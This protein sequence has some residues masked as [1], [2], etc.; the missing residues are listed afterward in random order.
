MKKILAILLCVMLICITPVVAFAEDGSVD[1]GEISGAETENSTPGEG[2]TT[3]G[4]NSGL[5][6]DVNT[7]DA[8][9]DGE[10]EKTITEQIKEWIVARLDDIAVVV[11]LIMTIIYNVRN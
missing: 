2:S 4:E 8:P 7:P 3:E 1:S 10:A 5:I 11:T 6:D 9:A